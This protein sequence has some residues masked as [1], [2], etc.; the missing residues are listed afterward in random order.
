MLLKINSQYVTKDGSIFIPRSH[1]LDDLVR[2][3]K[4]GGGDHYIIG[5]LRKQTETGFVVE[6][7]T[8]SGGDLKK[9]FGLNPKSRKESVDVE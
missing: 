2:D 3:N 4:G 5:E 1:Y 7:K 8:F 6:H 9:L